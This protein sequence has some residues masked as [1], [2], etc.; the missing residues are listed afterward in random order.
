MSDNMKAS[1]DNSATT[2]KKKHKLPH[3]FVILFCLVAVAS[4]LTWI[5]PA[6][7]FDL[8]LIHIFAF[9]SPFHLLHLFTSFSV[10]ISSMYVFYVLYICMFV[11]SSNA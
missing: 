9:F 8:S 10:S 2:V 11:Q 1:A 6:G 3:V 4:I 7:E 5:I